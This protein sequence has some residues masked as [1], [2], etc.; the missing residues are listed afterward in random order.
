MQMRNAKIWWKILIAV[1]ILL[2]IGAVASFVILRYVKKKATG[3]LQSQFAEL[4]EPAKKQFLEMLPKDY[5]KERA[6]KAFD[7]FIG[8]SQTGKLRVNTVIN[9]LAPYLQ[10]AMGDGM[11]KTEEAD[12]VLKLMEK[13]ILQ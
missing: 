7:S 5:D 2:I 8:A 9:Q 10:T 4:V 3:V 1:L 13:S 11:L 6:R 12:S